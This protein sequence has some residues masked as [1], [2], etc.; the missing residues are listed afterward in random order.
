MS[1]KDNKKV[2]QRV[3]TSVDPTKL[4]TNTVFEHIKYKVGEE[5]RDAYLDP[6]NLSVEETLSIKDS[7]IEQLDKIKEEIENYIEYPDEKEVMRLVYE[8][9]G[10][11]TIEKKVFKN[12]DYENLKKFI[13]EPEKFD[14]SDRYLEVCVFYTSTYNIRRS[15]R[16]VFNSADI[17]RDFC[18]NPCVVMTINYLQKRRDHLLK[19]TKEKLFKRLLDADSLLEAA[20]KES[21]DAPLNLKAVEIRLKI[22]DKMY[23]LLGAIDRGS[24]L[25]K[26]GIN[27]NILKLENNKAESKE[28]DIETEIEKE[29]NHE[30]D[31][32]G[33]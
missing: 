12:Y 7:I 20:Q 2:Y 25:A 26:E 10:N 21:E 22:T 29:D 32:D 24:I 4:R 8:Y 13:E 33:Y 5:F 23:D 9:L 18:N 27:I 11:Y 6:T 28:E 1:N 14:I 15:M 30:D 19:I 3:K 17:K 16:A 31:L